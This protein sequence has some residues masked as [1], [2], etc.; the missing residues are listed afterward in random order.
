MDSRNGGRAGFARCCLVALALPLAVLTFGLVASRMEARPLP[1]DAKASRDD[2]GKR[3]DRPQVKLGLV[4]NGPRAFQGYTVLNPMNKK[5]TYLIDMDGHVVHTWES[6]YNSMHAAYLLENGQLFRVAVLDGAERSFGGG[7]GSAGRIQEFTWEGELVWD[8]Q[9]HN[10]K[11]LHHHDAIKMPNGNVLMV[12]WDKK[13][14]DE[15]IA[16]GR[17]K[18]LVSKYL[19]PDSIVEVKP[20]GKTTGEVVWEWHLWDHLIQDND[21]TKAN[22]GDVAAHP[23]LVDINFVENSMGPGPGPPGPVAKADGKASDKTADTVKTADAVKKAEDAKLKSIGYVGSPQQRSQW[24]NPDWTHVNSVDYN[25]ELDQ[26]VISVHEFSEIWIIDHSTTTA[27]AAGHT[28]GR[29]GKGGDLLYRWGNPRVYRAGTKE[30][31]KL[32]AQHNAQW[33]RR[34]LPGEGH[35]LVFNNG[36]H[37]PDGNYSSVDE[38][39][40]PP[41]DD[42]GRY[43]HAPGK[44]F[45]PEA[46]IWSYSAPEK[47][48]FNAFFISGAQRLPNGNTFICS[49]PNGTLFE[50]T[51]DKEMVWKYVN[52]VKGGFGPGGPPP[53]NQ[54]LPWFV[55][56]RLDLSP[57]QK[58]EI[59]AFQKTVDQTLD[60]LLTD[61]QKKILRER[62]GPGPGGFGGMPAPGQ[63]LAVSTQITLK[64]TPE[65]RAKLADLQK[66]ADAKLDKVLTDAQKKQLKEIRAE[67]LRGGS[68]GPGGGPPGG[69]GNPGGPGGGPPAALFA[70]PPGGAG[71]FRAYRYGPDYPGLA[72]KDLEPGKTV[73]ELQPKEPEKPKNAE[74][75]K[76]AEKTQG[77]GETQGR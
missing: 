6:K 66:Q 14:A 35:L 31:Q 13:T 32:F 1:D 56:D 25:A 3:A 38:I 77:A 64:P 29:S 20:T 34:G 62:S 48:D 44:A 60:K 16:A 50:V 55:Q 22:Y 45:G 70:G 18:E 75:A 10:D 52:P 40:L 76:D 39:V 57:G 67:F 36:G 5:T 8:F 2:E 51:P 11:Q 58:Q 49:G 53:P 23:E 63:I 7:P 61:E 43:E 24:I 9:F 54:V 71:V 12:V 46:A 19:L 4:L 65:Q 74:K 17:K 15:A 68:G 42:K 37:R 26:I 73:E 28:G 69:P 59:D 72:G 27:E 33:I 21:P 41:V 30:D 47:S